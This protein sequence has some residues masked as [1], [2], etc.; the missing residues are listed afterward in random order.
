MSK[1]DINFV[2]TLVV[3]II[4]FVSLPILLDF[5]FMWE[6]KYI[7]TANKISTLG[8]ICGYAW[9]LFLS[10]CTFEFFDKRIK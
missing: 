4:V 8:G 6:G 9:L 7:P 5:D 1:E 10:Y 3:S 2:K